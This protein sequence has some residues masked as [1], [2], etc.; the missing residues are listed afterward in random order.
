[1]MAAKEKRFQWN[2]G[3]KVENLFQSLA[4]FKKGLAIQERYSQG[5][6]VV[7]QDF[8]SINAANEHINATN[9]QEVT[10]S[11]KILAR[12]MVNNPSQPLYQYAN[13]PPAVSD[14]CWNAWPSTPCRLR[15]QIGEQPNWVAQQ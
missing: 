3:D 14:N 4:N 12:A 6:S 1:M 5:K 2:K 13:Y 10:Q 7:Q 11:F 8:C 9:S 15:L